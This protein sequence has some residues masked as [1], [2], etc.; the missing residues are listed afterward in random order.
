[1]QNPS[2]PPGAPQPGPYRPE[3]Y[4]QRSPLPRLTWLL[5][6]LLL[7]WLTPVFV[8]RIEF[9]LVRGKERAEAEVAAGQ[10]P[11][12][13]LKEL[14]RDFSLV[15]KRIGP[16]VVHVETVRVLNG[17]TSDEFAALFGQQ[18]LLERGEG[19]GVIVDAAGYILTNNHVV[20]HAGEIEVRLSD[21][22]SVRG[23]VVGTDPATDIAVLKINASDLVVAEWGNS[24]ELEVGALVWAVGNPYGLDRS[25]TFGIISAKNRRGFENNPFQDF[26]QTDAAVNPGNSGGPLVNISGQIIG[27]NTAII[28]KAYQGISFAI[29]SSTAHV[30]YEKLKSTGRVARAWLGVALMDATPEL[31]RKLSLPSTKGALVSEVRPGAPADKAGIQPGDFIVEWNGQ[32]VDSSASL[33]LLVAKTKI[34]SKAKAVLFRDGEKKEV[35]VQVEERP[36]RLAR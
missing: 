17:N 32:P 20:D 18:Q 2:L 13:L 34:G 19:S 12:N 1:M 16:S 8:E 22:R 36:Q 9:A 35:E 24:E 30:V 6:L 31:A 10:L 3:Y 23:E 28:G 7:V 4:P 11:T 15:A 21:G 14:S 27:L 33:S 5:V 25:V 29:P 26:L